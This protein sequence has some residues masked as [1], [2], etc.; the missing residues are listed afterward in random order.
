MK[1]QEEQHLVAAAAVATAALPCS[2]THGGMLGL[3]W[4]LLAVAGQHV[5]TYLPPGGVCT[6][7]YQHAHHACAVGLCAMC[8]FRL[9]ASGELAMFQLALPVCAFILSEAGACRRCSI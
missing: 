2:A 3:W 1:S 6:L 7:C 8:E 5:G 4:L 9:G